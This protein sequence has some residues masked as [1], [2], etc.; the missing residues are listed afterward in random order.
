MIGDA[1]WEI[2]AGIDY[3]LMDDEELRQLEDTRGELLHIRGESRVE[4][5]DRRVGLAHHAHA[6]RRRRDNHLRFREGLD[7]TTREAKRLGPVAGVEVHLAA[8]RLVQR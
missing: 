1:V 2:R 6:R 5:R 8:A 4:L 3:P 7:E